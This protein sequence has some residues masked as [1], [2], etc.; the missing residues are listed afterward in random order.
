M[1]NIIIDFIS[2]CFFKALIIIDAIVFHTYVCYDLARKLLF[3]LIRGTRTWVIMTFR[4]LMFTVLLAP[5]WYKLL[6][7]WM[8]SPLILRNL[9]YGKGAKNR[10]LLD[11]YLPVPSKK[12]H[13]KKSQNRGTPVVIF[14][15]GGAWTIGYK[16][17]SALVARGLAKL[18]ILTIV[19]DYRNFPQGDVEDMMEDIRLSVEWT[20]ANAHRFGGDSEK[21]VLSG[22]SAG[23]HITLCLLVADYLRTHE[24]TKLNQ[25]MSTK[26]NG[27]EFL[28]D[29]DGLASDMDEDEE[30]SDS[31]VS[32]REGGAPIHTAVVRSSKP[33][34]ASTI[35]RSWLA[36][37]TANTTIGESTTGLDSIPSA[38]Y[39][40]PLRGSRGSSSRARKDP[41]SPEAAKITSRAAAA[42]VPVLSSPQLHTTSTTEDLPTHS[43]LHRHVFPHLEH[44]PQ[45]KN[46]SRSSTVGGELHLPS[47]QLSS[48]RNSKTLQSAAAATANRHRSQTC[49]GVSQQDRAEHP[50][51]E[52]KPHTHQ[53]ATH[54]ILSLIDTYL[55]KTKGTDGGDRRSTSAQFLSATADTIQRQFREQLRR[56]SIIG[57]TEFEVPGDEVSVQTDEEVKRSDE[58]TES[59][60]D[61]S[62]ESLEEDGVEPVQLQQR[63]AQ[64]E[65]EQEEALWRD[66]PSV[67]KEGA[68]VGAD[69]AEFLSAFSPTPTTTAVPS[70][71][72]NHPHLSFSPQP[73]VF[74]KSSRDHNG[75]G[76]KKKRSSKKKRTKFNVTSHIKLFIGVSG[77]YDLTSLQS[78]LHQRGLDSRILDWICRGDIGNYSP[79]SQLAAYAE[80]QRGVRLSGSSSAEKDS[81][82]H[83]H[84][85]RS[86][87]AVFATQYPTGTTSV[88]SD[89]TPVALF[90]GSRDASIPVSICTDLAEVLQ[91]HGANVLCKVYEG[92]SHT[93]A[94][95]EAPL[96]GTMRL[97]NDMAGVIFAHTAEVATEADGKPLAGTASHL[98][99]P[100]SAADEAEH[101]SYSSSPL[102]H[103]SLVLFPSL[104][105]GPSPAATGPAATT[106]VATGTSAEPS[107]DSSRPQ[108]TRP[109]S[110]HATVL[111]SNKKSKPTKHRSSKKDAAAAE[112][113]SS[114]MV[115]Q[116]L[117]KIARE[118][119]PF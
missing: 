103:L 13:T 26:S 27:D 65:E 96:S 35:D 22:Q 83:H 34:S 18:G 74:S 87:S 94:I 107:S 105:G 16:L 75:G 81:S 23:A 50:L 78:H 5:G 84:K 46:R 39:V 25:S 38:E 51:I 64:E 68:A 76:D 20:V 60:C 17:W 61:A 21:I 32:D 97:F 69:P 31:E 33:S 58:A 10:N 57:G 112:G 90:H 116:L 92:W 52:N 43:E 77:P 8:L 53:R 86:S 100:V 72:A 56:N 79:T 62:R 98:V 7:Y 109:G 12:S 41:F 73:V 71:A 30:G 111:K 24:E 88:L 44:D 70:S 82:G 101:K 113:K 36:P 67:R 19:P 118:I 63:R 106:T 14:V 37:A 1:L 55:D 3:F 95:L 42:N 85:R 49:I 110:N 48:R 108:K 104:F 2:R 9:R 4:L 89:L 114:A 66:V 59:D 15:S 99:L 40:T 29:S 47:S 80:S 117:V 119:N 93:D 28:D 11:V 54:S 102:D 115:S 6:R 45:P 91:T